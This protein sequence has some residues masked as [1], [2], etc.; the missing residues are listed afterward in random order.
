MVHSLDSSPGMS[1]SHSLNMRISANL[2]FGAEAEVSL[3]VEVSTI[4]TSFAEGG[5][6]LSFWS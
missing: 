6:P 2:F 5:S 1:T 4:W 3:D